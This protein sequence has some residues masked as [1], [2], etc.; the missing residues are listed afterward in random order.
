MIPQSAR[1]QPAVA[2]CAWRLFELL[3]AMPTKC[4]QEVAG[5]AWRPQEQAG[6]AF[7]LFQQTHLMRSNWA[8]D[9]VLIEAKKLGGAGYLYLME[10]RLSLSYNQ[11]HP[12]RM[13]KYPPLD[14]A[15]FK[16]LK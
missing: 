3:G 10:Q 11:Q 8:Q 13:N 12:F 2:N 15:Y 5:L 7:H 14:H 1:D 9:A 4:L 16:R 6:V